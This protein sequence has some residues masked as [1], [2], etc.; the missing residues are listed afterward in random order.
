MLHTAIAARRD[1]GL[2]A[3][4][5]SNSDSSSVRVAA[6]TAEMAWE[7]SDSMTTWVLKNHSSSMRPVSLRGPRCGGRSFRDGRAQ[8][9][10][11]I[12]GKGFHS[13]HCSAA[14]RARVTSAPMRLLAMTSV[15]P[16][17]GSCQKGGRTRAEV[18]GGLRSPLRLRFASGKREAGTSQ[19]VRSGLSTHRTLDIVIGPSLL[20]RVQL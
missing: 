14:R 17:R 2:V 19:Q 9:L 5:V 18:A 8:T 10:Q 16:S 13:R 11:T 6:M 15:A 12:T 7:A 4:W 3:N 1:G 20:I